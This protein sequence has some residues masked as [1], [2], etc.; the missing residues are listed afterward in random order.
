MA[1]L[2]IEIFKHLTSDSKR[3]MESQIN[4]DACRKF[5]EEE[6]KSGLNSDVKLILEEP[7]LKLKNASKDFVS[8]LKYGDVVLLISTD[9]AVDFLYNSESTSLE[10]MMER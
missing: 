9:N 8:D 10:E 7:N 4:I 5:H 2:Q 6:F 3:Y 1:K